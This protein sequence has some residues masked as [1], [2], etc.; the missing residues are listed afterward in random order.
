[1]VIIWGT[2]CRTAIPSTQPDSLHLTLCFRCSCIPFN[3]WLFVTVL[4][5]KLGL[6]G[7][8]VSVSIADIAK[9]VFIYLGVPFLGG[10]ITP[11]ALV[12]TK[13][14]PSMRYARSGTTYGR[15][16]HDAA[17]LWFVSVRKT[18]QA[19]LSTALPAREQLPLTD[20]S[21][22]ACRVLASREGSETCARSERT[23]PHP[24]IERQSATTLADHSPSYRGISLCTI[25]LSAV[26]AGGL[27]QRGVSDSIRAEV[28]LPNSL[29]TPNRA[30]LYISNVWTIGRR[31]QCLVA[32]R[33]GA[34]QGVAGRNPDTAD[35][36][37]PHP[38]R[39]R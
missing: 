27:A 1:M 2:N 15:P 10:F 7:A 39:G 36:R 24:L 26:S 37:R 11:T 38:G 13:G 31:P 12:R 8:V 9:S 17:R 30:D 29:R 18:D 4:A 22:A 34:V 3:A 32:Q 19:R 16:S 25:G 20:S 23:L 14:R 21:L 33:K 35:T 6:H 5:G 28:T